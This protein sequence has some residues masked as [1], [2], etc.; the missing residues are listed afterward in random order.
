M[1]DDFLRLVGGNQTLCAVLT[2]LL[3]PA[4]SS[5]L[6]A[7]LCDALGLQSGA[8]DTFPE[9]LAGLDIYLK[10]CCLGRSS[11]VVSR[12]LENRGTTLEQAIAQSDSQSLLLLI[13]RL[14]AGLTRRDSAWLSTTQ[15][16]TRQASESL[17]FLNP[18]NQDPL[19][20]WREVNRSL[21]L[22]HLPELKQL[23][24]VEES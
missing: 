9:V 11:T 8:G 3:A 14:E 15:A 6:L 10:T 22:H 23:I 7:A 2:P 19:L 1:S 20:G 13:E 16:F 24:G 5:R 17:G 4:H 18:W 21:E 12:F